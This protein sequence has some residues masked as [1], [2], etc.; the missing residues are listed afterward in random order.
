MW[1]GV[2]AFPCA[3]VPPSYPLLYLYLS[4]SCPCQCSEGGSE[5]I[6]VPAEESRPGHPSAWPCFVLRPTTRPVFSRIALET[7]VIGSIR[8]LCIF[9]SSHNIVLRGFS[10][11]QQFI[12]F[13]LLMR[14]F[15]RQIVIYRM[16]L[17]KAKENTEL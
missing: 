6:S 9:C 3:E 1:F 13:I 7:H 17:Y 12:D 4:H 10:P 8:P 5:H 14:M 15:L 16:K 2:T 11:Q